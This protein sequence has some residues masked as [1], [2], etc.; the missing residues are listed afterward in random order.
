VQANRLVEQ[1]R[2]PFSCRIRSG[3]ACG[4][5]RAP[6][7]IPVHARGTWHTRGLHQETAGLEHPDVT[8]ERPRRGCRLI[9]QVLIQGGRIKR[10]LGRFDPSLGGSPGV[11]GSLPVEIQLKTPATDP[12]PPNRS[13]TPAV[14]Y[15]NQF[16]IEFLSATN[17]IIEDLDPGPLE[18]FEPVLDT[19][20][21]VTGTG[22]QSDQGPGALQSVVMTRYRGAE[23]TEFLFTGFNIW[24]V[25]RTQCKELVYFVLQRMW[26]P[27]VLRPSPSRVAGRSAAVPRIS[28]APAG[29]RAAPSRQAQKAVLPATPAALGTRD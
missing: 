7:E 6:D 5:I 22:L 21:K 4:A 19:L 9:G 24:N 16:D 17:E 25:R 8:D 12:F 18:N 28:R 29:A 3:C 15:Q 2:H 20:Y 27:A 10:Y 26:G 14:F 13:V 1:L 11:Y 23:N